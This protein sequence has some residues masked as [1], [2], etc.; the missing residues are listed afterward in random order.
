MYLGR[1][2]YSID[3]DKIWDIPR[4]EVGMIECPAEE[5][6]EKEAD[7]RGARVTWPTMPPDNQ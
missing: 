1:L 7:E 3:Y 2:E 5:E 6:E 4:A